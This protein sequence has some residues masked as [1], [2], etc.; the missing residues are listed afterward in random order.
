MQAQPTG[1]YPDSDKRKRHKQIFLFNTQFLYP[2]PPRYENRKCFQEMQRN[3]RRL[4]H[5]K[6]NPRV[7][8]D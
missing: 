1:S 7:P 3:T 6:K 4:F 2:P 8:A 5:P